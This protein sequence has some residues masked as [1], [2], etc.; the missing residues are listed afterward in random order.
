MAV[1]AGPHGFERLDPFAV[2]EPRHD[3][4]EL[5]P[6]IVGDDHVDLLADRLGGRVSVEAFRARVPTRDFSRERLREDRVVRVLHDRG[7]PRLGFPRPDEL[8]DVDEGRDDRRL[9][10]QVEVFD[11]HERPTWVPRFRADLDLRVADCPAF[12]EALAEHPPLLLID[13]QV[14]VQRRSPDH[15][16]PFVPEHAEELEVHLEEAAVLQRA[17]AHRQRVLLEQE[18]IGLRFCAGTSLPPLLVR[19]RGSPRRRSRSDR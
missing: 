4:L 18:S 8:R 15:L 19:G 12:P 14:E 1:L 3:P 16:A 9:A 10:S 13:P 17:D 11:R 5:A 2:P 6:S 7:E